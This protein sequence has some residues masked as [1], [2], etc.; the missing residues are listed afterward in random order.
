ML[1][2]CLAYNI[3]A[4]LS[5]CP[6]VQKLT[7]IMVLFGCY[8]AGLV[9]C[10]ASQHMFCVDHTTMHRCEATYAGCMCVQL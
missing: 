4:S 1:V 2:V 8:M 6:S 7:I 3:S 10:E 5:F 9:L